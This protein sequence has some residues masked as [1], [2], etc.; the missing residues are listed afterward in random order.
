LQIFYGLFPGHLHRD[1]KIS[2][3]RGY[4]II[5]LSWLHLDTVNESPKAVCFFDIRRRRRGRR[6]IEGVVFVGVNAVSVSIG[7]LQPSIPSKF[8]LFTVHKPSKS[9]TL[10][11]DEMIVDIMYGWWAAY[12]YTYM[13]LGFCKRRQ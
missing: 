5:H 12:I 2:C 11:S 6:R 7:C 1:S 9:F 4:R 8:L 13:M 3:R 10:D